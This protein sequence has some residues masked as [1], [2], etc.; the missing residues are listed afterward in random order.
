MLVAN[1]EMGDTIYKIKVWQA[2]V[3]IFDS[4]NEK[5]CRIV[6]EIP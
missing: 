2:K 5:G 6:T 1:G 3:S 4:L